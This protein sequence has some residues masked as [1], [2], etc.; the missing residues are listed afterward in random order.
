LN[1]NKPPKLSIITPSLNHGP[2]LRDT[3]ESIMMQTYADFEHIV[4]DGGS[5]D[6]TLNILKHYP[7][8]R[9]ISEKETDANTILEAYRKAIAMAKGD[10]V[11][12]CCVTDGFLDKNWFASC[13]DILDADNEVSLVWGLS[14]QMTEEGRMGKI[15]NAHFLEKPPPQKRAFLAFWFAFGLGF[16]E[17]NYMVRRAVLDRCFPQRNC[18][19][20]MSINPVWT[21]NYNFNTMGYLP[22]FL[23]IIASYV[24]DHRDKRGIRLYEIEDPASRRYIKCMK[25]FRKNFFRGDLRY[26]IRNGE[27][28]IIEHLDTSAVRTMKKT[29]MQHLMKYKLRKRLNEIMDKL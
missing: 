18:Q 25:D 1:S 7:H 8:V 4:V 6:D 10:Y 20:P 29:Y 9:W 21:F 24:R 15:V 23:P 11:I 3:I 2:F 14:Q 27:S 28:E 12:Q 19:E 13:V 26:C 22:Y 17:F 5:T 16:P